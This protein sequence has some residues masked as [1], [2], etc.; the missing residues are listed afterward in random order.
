MRLVAGLDTVNAS[1]AGE[2]LLIQLLEAEDG[3]V[4]RLGTPVMAR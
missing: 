4:A 2:L 3:A 1:E